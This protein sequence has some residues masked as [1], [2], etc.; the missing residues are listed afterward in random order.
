MG[1]QQRRLRERRARRDAIRT[2]AL[3]LFGD[4]GFARTTVADIARQAEVSVGT[5]YLH[6][7]SKEDLYVSVLF[8]SMQ[9]F[10]EAI[11]A[12]IATA[13]PP[14]EQLA[15]VWDF[16]HDYHARSPESHQALVFLQQPGLIGAL[17]RKTTQEINVRAARNFALVSRIVAT[18]MARGLYRRH[19]PRE[20]VDLL[21][22][23]FLGLVHLSETRASLG[24]TV[25]TLEDLHRKAFAW[26]EEGLRAPG[27]RGAEAARR[28][29]GTGRARGRM[30]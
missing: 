13:L 7:R 18:G 6:Y 23:L 20:V 16:F 12:I 1:T 29:S 22:S 14:D 10:T 3:G 19:E 9:R 26:V 30:A 5:I 27:G 8:E 4:K 15:R 17:S 28:R 11:E 21:W 2:A 24:V 25:S